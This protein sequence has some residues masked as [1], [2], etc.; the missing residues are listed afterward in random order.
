MARASAHL[1]AFL[2]AAAIGAVG[3]LKADEPLF[4]PP[5][6]ASPDG[7]GYRA[8]DLPAPPGI[9]A[10]ED[11]APAD[12]SPVAN[13]L[14]L[15][16][17]RRLPRA[18]RQSGKP[19]VPQIE[20]YH[21]DGAWS[22]ATLTELNT[23]FDPRLATVLLVH[24][25]HT[26]ESTAISKGLAAYRALT[27][28][29]PDARPVRLLIWSWPTDFIPGGVRR[30]ARVKAE[31]AED[32]AFYLAGFVAGLDPR[33]SVTLVGYSFG[34]R[35]ISGALHL[36]GGG[37]LG[38]RPFAT[39]A[40][41]DRAPLRAVLLAAAV[42]DDWLLPGHRHG[43]AL[44]A[45]ERMVV[46]VNPQDRVLRWYRF[47]VP[48]SHATALGS[49]G[50]VNRAALGRQAQKLVQL[51]AHQAVGGQHGWTSY[52]S[53]PEVVAQLRRE[54]VT[55]SSRRHRTASRP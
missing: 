47:L 54:L 43:N 24:G 35:A 28:P 6:F 23:A 25:N 48:R 31:W 15:V 14:W 5:A 20:R 55:S 12:D 38:K 27:E 34:A 16:N 40:P 19:L 13:Q 18:G 1:L 51:N 42:D 52:I 8:G 44:S 50:V 41:F 4:P 3:V 39:A 46:T 17:T 10:A 7:R 53:S 26:E 30:D 37:K 29:S 22:P 2:M 49:H 21:T 36:L 45:V 33:E 11:A 32:E 9:S